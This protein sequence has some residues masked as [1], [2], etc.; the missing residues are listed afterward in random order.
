MRELLDVIESLVTPLASFGISN[1]YWCFQW[2][3]QGFNLTLQG[4]QTNMKIF[5]KEI[6]NEEKED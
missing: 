3:H 4:E 5:Y 1:Y 6:K 2:K